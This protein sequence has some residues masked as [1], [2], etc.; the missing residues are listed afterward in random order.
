MNTLKVMNLYPEIT[1]LD[2]VDTRGVLIIRKNIEN[3]EN[4]I[5]LNLNLVKG[6]YTLLFY[7]KERMIQTEKLLVI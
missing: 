3:G 6:Y 4:A 1:Q 2:V 5:E 7:G